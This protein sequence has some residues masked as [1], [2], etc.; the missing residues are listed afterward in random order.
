[1]GVGEGAWFVAW[2][3]GERRRERRGCGIIKRYPKGWVG[4]RDKGDPLDT[5]MSGGIPPT[6]TSE[7]RLAL[8]RTGSY[9]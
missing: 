5:F 1:M 9:Y 8:L 2:G 3:G 4:G 6:P 7:I